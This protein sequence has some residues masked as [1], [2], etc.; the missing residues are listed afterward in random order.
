MKI[1]YENGPDRITAGIAGVFEKNKA[2]EVSDEIAKRLLKKP[3]FNEAKE[4]DN[5]KG[6]GKK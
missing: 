1:F 3:M 2:K 4:R 5:N 6:K